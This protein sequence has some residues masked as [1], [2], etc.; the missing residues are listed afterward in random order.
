MLLCFI[1]FCIL[2]L[3]FIFYFSGSGRIGKIYYFIFY[4]LQSC[5][6][7]TTCLALVSTLAQLANEGHSSTKRLISHDT[8]RILMRTLACFGSDLDW[9]LLSAI[10]SLLSKLGQKGKRNILH[11]TLLKTNMFC[12]DAICHKKM[13]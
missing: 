6:D 2:F 3:I 10:I 4:A 8:T 5:N 12:F 7:Q 9:R 1:I 11:T 13:L